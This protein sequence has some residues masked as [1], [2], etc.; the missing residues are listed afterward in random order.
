MK[1]NFE[2]SIDKE[3]FDEEVYYTKGS[4]RDSILVRMY[5]DNNKFNINNIR[6][7]FNENNFKIV[8]GSDNKSYLTI[9]PTELGNSYYDLEL[10]IYLMM[11]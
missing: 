9:I 1:I 10:Y 6:N 5:Y 8:K 2:N 3:E 4:Y 11:N 7:I